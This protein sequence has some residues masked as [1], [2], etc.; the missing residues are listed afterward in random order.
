MWADLTRLLLSSKAAPDAALGAGSD[1]SGTG[2]VLSP[3]AVEARREVLEGVDEAVTAFLKLGDVEGIHNCAVLA[4]N[5]GVFAARWVAGWRAGILVG[6][7]RTAHVPLTAGCSCQHLAKQQ[8]AVRASLVLAFL[9]SSHVCRPAAA[10]A[11]PPRPA[12]AR[13]HC[14][15]KGPGGCRQP[16]EQAAC[17]SALG[18]GKSRG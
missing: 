9:R 2:A 15:C 10:A 12:Q 11:P 8:T 17:C 3:A 18:G 1:S 7:R 13:V 5:T 14:C 6:A 16:L 4:W